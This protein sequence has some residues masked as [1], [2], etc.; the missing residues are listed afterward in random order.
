M[1][2]VLGIIGGSGLYQIEGLRNTEWKTVESPFG[3]PSDALLCGTIGDLPVVF[4][5][6]HGRNHALTPS[7][8]NYRANIDVLKRAGVTDI[9]AL[10]ACGSFVEEYKPGDFVLIDDYIDRTH[11]RVNTFFEP[12]LV[13]HVSMAKPVCHR[14]R[15]IITPQL[16][17]QTGITL[18][19]T[20]TYVCIEGPQFLTRAE[21]L[22]YKNSGAHIVGMTNMPEAKLAREA[23]ICYAA[24]GMVTDFDCWHPHHDAV[25]VADI[26]RILNQNADHARALVQAVAAQLAASREACAQG[27]NSVLDMAVTT[28]P[29]ARDHALSHK[30][31]AIAG[32][33]FV[34]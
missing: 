32:R 15:D 2:T 14:L 34:S 29:A 27:C 30:L 18:H 17:Q 31:Y 26:I 6:R 11:L 13:A 5:P 7:H 9:L 24:I 3:A 22:L 28:P 8:I 20:G 10:S 1:Q 25:Q 23:E 21:S 33:F 16:A 4:L 19:R 12:G